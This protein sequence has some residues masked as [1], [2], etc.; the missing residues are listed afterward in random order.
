[1]GVV[2]TNTVALIMVVSITAEAKSTKCVPSR[3]PR[4]RT[5]GE[6]RFSNPALKGL[7][8]KRI[9]APRT[10][11]AIVKRQKAMEKIST[12]PISLMNTAAVPKEAPARVPS[13]RAIF[14][15]R[16]RCCTAKSRSP[17]YATIGVF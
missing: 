13:K 6:N 10:K 14:L 12:P 15:P 8:N 17:R 16:F 9:A 11:K 1:M 5:C 3:T 4:K 7:L 2:F